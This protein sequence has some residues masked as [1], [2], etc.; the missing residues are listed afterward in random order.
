MPNT[1]QH[2]ALTFVMS[3]RQLISIVR[4]YLPGP[5]TLNRIEG[6]AT[7]GFGAAE[8]AGATSLLGAPEPVF[9]KVAGVA[10]AAHGVDM[11]AAGRRAW[12]TGTPSQTRTERA[13]RNAALRAHASPAVAGLAGAAADALIPGSL[14]HAVSSFAATRAIRVAS[15]DAY[16][17]TFRH[18]D[19]TWE[20]F[21]RPSPYA[22]QPARSGANQNLI[23]HHRQKRFDGDRNESLPHN[24]KVGGHILRKHVALSDEY[25][26]RRFTKEK[27]PVISFFT[28]Q[29]AAE[30]IIHKV[31]K[32]NASKLD[33]WL[34]NAKEGAQISLDENISERETVVIEKADRQR[35]TPLKIEIVII[36]K[37]HNGLV[38]Y[39]HTAK[40]Y[41]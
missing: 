41:K 34:K 18:A 21:H 3:E 14:L 17:L 28:T 15:A 27:R 37:E 36:K 12:N 31:L 25:I 19:I 7:I 22:S 10:L 6:L 20:H 29:A 2:P 30:R 38:Y 16:R 26:E 33:T 24:L 4:R 39:V 11:M 23:S 1:N 8:M 13:V 35:K 5:Q 9:S 40:M 32:N